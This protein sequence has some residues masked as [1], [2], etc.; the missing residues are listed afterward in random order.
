MH[1]RGRPRRTVRQVEM[2]TL[3]GIRGGGQTGRPCGSCLAQC[4]AAYQ[5]RCGSTW[6]MLL[7][8]AGRPGS[9]MSKTMMANMTCTIIGVDSRD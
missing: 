7:V 4:P 2:Q 6:Y 5:I 8:V 3:I 1:G 9:G